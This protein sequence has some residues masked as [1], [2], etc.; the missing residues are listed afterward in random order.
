MRPQ[1]PLTNTSLVGECPDPEYTTVYRVVCCY[2]PFSKPESRIL[3]GW[4]GLNTGTAHKYLQVVTWCYR[5]RMLTPLPPQRHGCAWTQVA[6]QKGWY[7]LKSRIGWGGMSNWIVIIVNR[8]IW[9]LTEAYWSGVSQTPSV[10]ESS[11]HCSRD[12]G[13]CIRRHV[14]Q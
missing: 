9:R 6:C 7:I 14:N 1:S 5:R 13:I 3:L 4:S 10:G 2:I 11:C 12:E 8:T